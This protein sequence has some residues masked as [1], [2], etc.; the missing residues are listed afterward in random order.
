ML[1]PMITHYMAVRSNFG[2]KFL[3]P[4]IAMAKRRKQHKG[5]GKNKMALE[6]VANLS[7]AEARM[8]LEAVCRS[9]EVNNS[10]AF[11]SLLTEFMGTLEAEPEVS[12]ETA[13]EM[14]REAREQADLKIGDVVKSIE[15]AIEATRTEMHA[16]LQ[17]ARTELHALTLPLAKG[18]AQAQRLVHGAYLTCCSTHEVEAIKKLKEADRNLK[19]IVV[20]RVMAV[21]KD[22]KDRDSFLIELGAAYEG[23]LDNETLASLLLTYHKMQVN[24]QVL[25]KN[26][27]KSNNQVAKERRGYKRPRRRRCAVLDEPTSSNNYV[28]PFNPFMPFSPWMQHH[29]Q[30]PDMGPQGLWVDSD[31]EAP[32]PILRAAPKATRSAVAPEAAREAAAPGATPKATPEVAAAPKATP[33]AHTKKKFVI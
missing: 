11:L 16:D 22:P 19:D 32:T 14:Q 15:L 4:P 10:P 6:A 8:L 5:V 3:G 33:K 30:N 18:A 31:P 23:I 27:F 2:S 13:A 21:H 9:P 1:N 29:F 28:M 20:H 12:P 7:G 25:L 26:G 17:A 24:N